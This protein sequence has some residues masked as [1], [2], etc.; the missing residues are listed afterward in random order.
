MFCSPKKIV[1]F[2]CFTD[3][4]KGSFGE[5]F[6]LKTVVRTGV[7]GIYYWIE[8][9]MESEEEHTGRQMEANTRSGSLKHYWLISLSQLG[10]FLHSSLTE[11]RLISCVARDP[12]SDVAPLV[13]T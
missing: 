12:M 6:H 3:E 7:L 2:P 10:S 13:T 5:T 8:V 4:A 11:M 9:R 1:S